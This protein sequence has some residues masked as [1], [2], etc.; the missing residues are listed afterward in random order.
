MTRSDAMTLR[1]RTV[2]T[3]R[4]LSRIAAI[5]TGIVTVVLLLLVASG[6]L[7]QQPTGEVRALPTR[8]AGALKGDFD[9]MLERRAIRVLV[10]YSRTLYFTDKGSERG[11][12]ADF[13][14][15]FERY[16]NTKYHKQLGKRPLTVIIRPTTRDL[17]LKDLVAGFGDIAAGNLTA[18]DERTKIVDFIAPADQ[19][20]VSELVLIGPKSPEIA[21]AGD[22]SGK[23]V[24]VRKASSYYESLLALNAQLK[25][26]GKAPVTLV[27]VPDALEDE[28]MMEMLNAGLLQAIVVDDWKARIW[29]QILPDI[30]INEGA[31]VRTGG[32]LGWA[33]RKDSPRLAAVLNDYYASYVKQHNLIVAR[34]KQYY[35]RVRQI[36]DSYGKEDER[37]FEATLALF[38]KYGDQYR[39]DPLMLTAQGYQESRLDQKAKSPTGAIGIMQVLPATGAELKVGDIRNIEPNIHAGAKYLDRLMS[40]HLADADLDE[41]NRTLFAFACYNAGPGNIVRMR[42]EAKKRGL[43][44]NVWFNNVELVTAE[45]IGMETTTYVR[46]I[47]K[48]YVAYR[49]LLDVQQAQAQARG[50]VNR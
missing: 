18:T 19:K 6:S 31:A 15:D 30:T 34:M 23:R 16:V 1:G 36:R 27:L 41:T 28:D 37:R 32:L 11:V 10:P 45:K 9:A 25:Q 12:T 38:R 35:S 17:L 4:R 13:V 5:S 39:F 44:P 29:A 46:N 48:Y 21:T 49:L 26:D 8:L 40:R 3:C 43:N 20:P 14:R 33:I 42:K 22:L 2:V 24:H 7:A 50:A 47:Y